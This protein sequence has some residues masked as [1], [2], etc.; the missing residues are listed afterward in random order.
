MSFLIAVGFGLVL[1][2][3]FVFVFWGAFS[4]F[5][6]VV[7]EIKKALD[8]KP[9]IGTVQVLIDQRFGKSATFGLLQNDAALPAAAPPT[10][11]VPAKL[12]ELRDL[13]KGL[14]D[15]AQHQTAMAAEHTQTLGAVSKTANEAHHR[16]T[17]LDKEIDGLYKHLDQFRVSLAD[18]SKGAAKRSELRPIRRDVAKLQKQVRQLGE[19]IDGIVAAVRQKIAAASAPPAPANAN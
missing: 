1:G 9:D 3:G 12:D 15:H 10:D 6:T 8:A 2:L 5:R 11:P 19:A 7:L 13:I 16:L 17:A 4:K 18:A 14:A